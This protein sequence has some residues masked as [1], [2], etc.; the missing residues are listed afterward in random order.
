[1]GVKCDTK[2]KR[3]WMMGVKTGCSTMIEDGNGFMLSP[4]VNFLYIYIYGRNSLVVW[5]S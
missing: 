5:P 2:D 1:M 4:H 3:K